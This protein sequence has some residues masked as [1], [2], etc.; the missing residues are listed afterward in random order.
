[1]IQVKMPQRGN[2]PVADCPDAF[3][4]SGIFNIATEDLFVL[5]LSSAWV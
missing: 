4:W 3:D 2:S 1:M 5:F